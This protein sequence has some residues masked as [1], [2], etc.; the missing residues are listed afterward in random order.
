V[1]IDSIFDFRS[2][3]A[4]VCHILLTLG[5]LVWAVT[6]A[7]ID[8]GHVGVF[9][10]DGIY[11]ASAQ[12]LRDGK[13]YQLPSR[14]DNPPPKYPIGFPLAISLVLNFQWGPHS[15]AGDIAAARCVVILSGL[16]FF[17]TIYLWLRRVR[18][19]APPA[20]AIVLTTA[21]HP[22]TLV[23]CSSAIFSDLT[24]CALTYSVFLQCGRS[25]HGSQ[26]SLVASSIWAGILAATGYL[27][28]SN[29]VTL[30]LAT[31]INSS[32]R[33]CA[34]ARLLGNLTG[35]T[36][37]LGAASLIPASS[38]RAVPSGDYALEMRAGW[39]S[40]GAG[41]KLLAANLAAVVLD[42]PVR[43]LLPVTTYISPV[44]RILANIPLASTALRLGCS[45]IVVLGVLRML[46]LWRTTS[47]AVW[48]HSLA[49]IA[50]FLVWPWTMIMDRFLLGLFP[51]VLL[52]FWTGLLELGRRTKRILRLPARLP[53]RLA[54]G[55]LTLVTLGSIGVS[56][57]AV[58]GFHSQ[59]RQWPGASNRR[60]LSEALSLIEAR[61]ESDA[62]IAARWP[63]TVYLYTGRQAV[64]LTEDDAILLGQFN[65]SD[66]LQLWMD[67]IPTRPFYLL[68]RSEIEDPSLA[69]RQQAD[70]LA[71]SPGLDLE[72]IAQTSDG[73][74]KVIQVIRHRLV[75]H[76]HQWT[77]NSAILDS[78][79]SSPSP[80][81]SGT[82]T[83]PSTDRIGSLIACRSVVPSSTTNSSKPSVFGTLAR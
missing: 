21:F 11:L 44:R 66:R 55:T 42:L 36:L 56:A 77:R 6:A 73:R 81:A 24:F 9:H 50:L 72:S 83:R 46:D 51:L 75:P 22:A 5:L 37:V 30:M 69:D 2:N 82:A 25:R 41:A 79:T 49:T 28:R 57:R 29:G 27:V 80:G 71:R 40:P 3:K 34:R 12:A 18:V 53:A 16:V 45:A 61:L 67:Q 26:N 48:C 65:C 59:G 1:E 47:I 78:F 33:T 4:A 64:P 39:S 15:L 32:R 7:G 13:G 31:A 63:D 17:L 8:N 19:P 58:Y 14:P 74:Y 68:L 43:V 10:D 23:G 62:V 76:T 70:A 60:S 38:D 54:L 52:A 20:V 35:I